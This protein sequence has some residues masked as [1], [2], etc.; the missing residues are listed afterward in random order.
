MG[1]AE[2]AVIPHGT[3]GKAGEVVGEGIEQ[4]C[5][6]VLVDDLLKA[7][8]QHLSVI[9]V[10]DLAMS[11]HGEQVTATLRQDLDHEA[12]VRLPRC[13]WRPE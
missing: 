13:G 2:G 8:D 1:Q 9:F 10:S 11:H 5:L 7:R 12:H 3:Q 4:S 6:T